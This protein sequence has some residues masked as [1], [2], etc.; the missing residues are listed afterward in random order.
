[1]LFCGHGDNLG[2]K[3]NSSLEIINSWEIFEKS[4]RPS[5]QI[6]EILRWE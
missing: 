5:P 6:Q 3:K 4:E 1:M 2:E